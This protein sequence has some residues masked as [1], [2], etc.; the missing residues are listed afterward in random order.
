MDERVQLHD[1]LNEVANELTVQPDALFKRIVV[2]QF[3]VPI[4]KVGRLKYMNEVN[5]DNLQYH[6][7]IE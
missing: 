2:E 6:S 5:R 1:T 7:R 4:K 3:H